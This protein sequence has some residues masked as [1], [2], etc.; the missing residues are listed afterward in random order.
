MKPE[1]WHD[2]WSK[3]HIGFHQHDFNKH[4]QSFVSSLGVKPG[5]HIFV[6]LCGKS[7]DMMWLSEQGYRVTGVEISK[8]AVEDFFAE[9][10]LPFE[11]TRL[12]GAQLYSAEN[13]AIYCADFF[14]VTMKHTPKID[15][16]YDRAS[17]IALPLAMRSAYVNRLSDLIATGTRS[18]LVTLDYPDQQMSG[19]PFSVTPAEV[20]S[21]YGTQYTIENIHSEDCLANQPRFQKMGL[22]R[23][24]EHV[25]LVEKNLQ[26]S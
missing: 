4:M 14:D 3:G 20:E 2:I 23:L 17:L 13:I 10:K 1:F 7:L 19:P 16:V 21:L 8:R 15:A 26:S 9:N 25:F 12:D 18:L 22:T 5:G 11:V 6:P 24:D